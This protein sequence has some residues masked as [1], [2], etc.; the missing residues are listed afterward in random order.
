MRTL[1]ALVIYIT[2]WASWAIDNVLGRCWGL[3]AKTQSVLFLDCFEDCFELSL[4][5]QMIAVGDRLYLHR[6]EL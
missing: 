1:L 6:K 5:V 3:A 4:L 2:Y